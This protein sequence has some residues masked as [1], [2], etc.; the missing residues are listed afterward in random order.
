MK[1]NTKQN[2]ITMESCKKIFYAVNYYA[3]IAEM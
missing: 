2:N 1:Q 3:V